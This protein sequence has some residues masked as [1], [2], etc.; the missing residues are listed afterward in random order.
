M[1]G[2]VRSMYVFA[3]TVVV[4]VFPITRRVVPKKSKVWCG[5]AAGMPRN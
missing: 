1:D 5:D 3:G 4:N 2:I